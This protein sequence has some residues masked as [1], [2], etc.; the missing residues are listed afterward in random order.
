MTLP[1]IVL[2]LMVGWGCSSPD[3]GARRDAVNGMVDTAEEWPGVLGM[4]IEKPEGVASCTGVLIAPNLLLTARHCVSS[5]QPTIVCGS[6][7][8]SPPVAG[9]NVLS[10]TDV[11][12]SSSSVA[13]VG[14]RVEVP[15]DGDDECGFDIAAVILRAEAPGGSVVYPPRLDA[16]VVAGETFTAVGYGTTG[17]SGIG[18]RRVATDVPVS[19]VGSECGISVVQETE[20][21]ADDGFFCRSDSGAPAIDASGQVIGVVSKGINPCNT[22]VLSSVYAWREWIRSVGRDAAEVGDYPVPEWAVEEVLDAGVGTDAG[23]ATSDAA[24]GDDGGS[25]GGGC[26]VAASGGAP[27]WVLVA[28]VAIRRRR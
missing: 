20:W 28:L 13:V 19:C 1:R 15:P 23:I 12:V 22:P 27:L 24:V 4:Q 10:T 8:L 7:P 14:E 16:P 3:V 2:A 9:E 6:S 26:S 17:T 21:V 25:D 5:T 18:T 11:T